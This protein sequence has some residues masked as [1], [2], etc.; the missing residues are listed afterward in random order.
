MARG[1]Q[2]PLELWPRPLRHEL[3]RA[4]V[5]I[6]HPAP[7]SQPVRLTHEE[8]SEAHSLDVAADHGMNPLGIH[9]WYIVPRMANSSSCGGSAGREIWRSRWP[10]PKAG[11]ARLGA[12][13]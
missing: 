7:Q 10:K 13:L 8:I 3:D 5:S 4:I 9:D 11:V 6:S 1:L 2:E 12:H